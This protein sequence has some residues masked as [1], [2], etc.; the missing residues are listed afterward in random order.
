[1]SK[2]K[3]GICGA[4]ID[5]ITLGEYAA[6][7]DVTMSVRFQSREFAGES[8]EWFE[9]WVKGSDPNAAE[10]GATD[11]SVIVHRE[12]TMLAGVVCV[13]IYGYDSPKGAVLWVR[14]IAV[15][16]EFQGRGVGRK[17]LQQALAYGTAK[18]AKRAFLIADN[19]NANAIHLYKSAGFA[20]REDEVQLDMVYNGNI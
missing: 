19:C 3:G 2:I 16:P 10:V 13:G 7:S 17:L 9:S 5:F 4:D 14:E 20:A 1:M 11:C 6:A 8:P 18:G 15:R 12:G